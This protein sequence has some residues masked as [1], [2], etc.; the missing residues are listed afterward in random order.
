MKTI[1]TIGILL[2]VMSFFI[3]CEFEIYSENTLEAKGINNAGK[4]G[5]IVYSDGSISA[6]YDSRKK[7]VGIVI[8]LKWGVGVATK[9]V[10]LA[11]TTAEWSPED[12]D[13][14]ARSTTD[15]VANMT[16]IQNIEGWEEKYPAFKWCDNYTDA[17]GNSDWYLPAEYELN[18]LYNVK[19]YVNA[20]ISRIKSGGGSAT[21]LSTDWYWSSSQSAHG[22][23]YFAL[24]QRFSD[25]DQDSL[26]PKGITYSVRAVRA[27]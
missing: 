14:N 27:F 8:E 9:I 16:A 19:D 1:R 10:S 5:D 13:T 17:S 25:G 23:A 4:I 21:Y 6:E 24:G 22:S 12:V 2:L 7:P 20:A 18:Q 11:E 3:G 26:C 15:G